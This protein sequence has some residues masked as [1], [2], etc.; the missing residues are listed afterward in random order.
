MMQ[1][2]KNYVVKDFNVRD[3]KDFI[4]YVLGIDIGGTNTNLGVA[5]IRNKRPTL[6][7]SLN[8]KSQELPSLVP[9]I[10]D[11]LNYA[12]DKYNVEI[13]NACI[14]AAG[15]V[16]PNK[17]YAE[18]THVKWNVN[19]KE[20]LNGTTLNSAFIINDFQA[21]G[22]GI[23]LLDYNNKDDIFLVKAGKTNINLSKETK[24]IIGAGTG[25]GKSILIYDERVDAYIPI[26]SE[27]GHGDF[28]AQDD[29]EI[30]LLNFIK[31]LRSISQPVTYE[32]L[33][34]GRGIE[35]IYLIL[36]EITETKETKYTKEIEN[37][38]DK[39]ALISKYRTEDKIC[40]ETFRL[41]ARYYG[42]CAKNFVLDTMSTGGLFIAGGIAAKNKDIFTTK[43]FL[44]EFENAH[45]R[46]DVLKQTPIYVITN[47]DVSIY[48]ACFAAMHNILDKRETI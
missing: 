30:Q 32:E 36:K 19:T 26:P 28:P 43:E 42:R 22:Y 29:F 33:L 7:F 1:I 21:I 46:K 3:E 18:L 44:S 9:A 37:A 6:L 15:V 40:G 27:G 2:T 10:K 14:G 25:L 45:Q 31:K 13:K 12:K 23:N 41:F 8:F 4:S 5:G 48:G 35:S 17:E 16:S 39:A 24:A 47:Y 38:T 20:I 11:A 34:S